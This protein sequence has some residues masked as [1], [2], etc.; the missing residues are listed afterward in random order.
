MPVVTPRVPIQTPM[1]DA[2]GLLTRTWVIF[3]ERLGLL[4]QRGSDGAA[5]GPYVRVLLLKDLTVG[6]DIAEHQY[7]FLPTPASETAVGR[8]IVAVLT[9]P[10]TADLVV[11]FRNITQSSVIA[12][13]T[14]PAATPI[15]TPVQVDITNITLQDEDVIGADITASD[16]Q[17]NAQG[18][19]AMTLEW[20][21]A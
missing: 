12:S 3:F 6:N 9:R 8:R 1:F 13:I 2:Q 14:V 19:C 18:I 17:V 16:G 4:G 21:P 7:I 20:E 11:R 10:I 5:T 15:D